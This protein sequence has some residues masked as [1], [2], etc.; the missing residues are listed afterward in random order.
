MKETRFFVIRLLF[1][2]VLCSGLAA[3][4]RP[5]VLW[6]V[7][8]DLRTELGC[9]G[10]EDV[11]SPNIDRL[12]AKGMLFNKAYAQ[13]PVCNP[14]RASFTTGLRPN[15]VGIL[16]NKTPLRRP[17]PNLVTLPQ[18]FRE[19]GYKTVGIGKI[20][21]LSVD[22]P[23]GKRVLFED[24]QSWDYFSDTLQNTTPLGRK[25]EGRNLTGGKLK[26]AHWRAAEGGDLGQPDGQ[27]ADALVKKLEEI[28]DEPFFIGY[29]IHKPHDPF[30]A[31]KQYF[32]LY[33][34]GSTKLEQEPENRSELERYALPNQSLFADF[35]DAERSEFKRA[36]QACVSF[37]DAQLGKVFATMDRLNLWDNTIV[38]LMSDH[39][40]HLGHKG[41]WNKVT[42]FETSARVPF[43][44]W[45]PNS[46][47]MGQK[48]ESIIELVDIYPTLVDLAGL[49]A[50]HAL[51]GKSMRPILDDP[52]AVT[53]HMAFTQVQRGKNSGRSIRSPR[54]RYTEWGQDGELGVE[55]YDHV[56]DPGEFYN[57]ARNPEYSNLRSQL[58][59]ALDEGFEG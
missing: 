26:W 23:D 57:L 31:P 21:H 25:G 49:Q 15:E 32:D 16:S 11:I 42:L 45:S 58:K 1:L 52:N 8:D 50:P 30:V 24:P 40:Y 3:Q 54:W 27:N 47:G 55:L 36:Y 12:A 37:V 43:I 20:Y 9:Y 48:T 59:R 2:L 19:N 28:H 56:K 22:D 38:I 10:A 33:P 6:I 39:G 46:R 41:W 44:V 13:Y 18:L 34:E 35:T 5:N 7:L 51:S 14:S 17:H 53:K 29:G 4:E